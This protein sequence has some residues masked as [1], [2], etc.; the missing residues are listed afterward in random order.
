MDE[1]GCDTKS[2]DFGQI[3]IDRPF[4]EDKQLRE[5]FCYQKPKGPNVAKEWSRNFRFKKLLVQT[6]P[7]LDWLVKYSWKHDFVKDIIS[8]ITVAIMHIPQGMAYAMLGNVPA[9]VGIYMAFFPVM[10]YFIFG[11]SKHNSMGTFSVACLMTGK[12]VLEY[13]DPS[14]FSTKGNIDGSTLIEPTGY[15]PIQVA[16]AVTFI[17]ALFQLAMYFLRLG[18]I[19]ALLSET[20]VSGFT[21]GAAI[22]VLVS[23]IKDLFGLQIPK[24]K[25]N[26]S[27]VYTIIAI[28]G[29]LSKTN[30]AALIIS[31]ITI[32][33]SVLNN[34]FFKPIVA[35][36]SPLPFPME[37]IAVVVGTLMSK[38]CN[39]EA[40]Y[41]I[42]VVGDIPVGLPE[43]TLPEFSLLSNLIVDGITISI[44]TYTINLS[45]ALIFAQKLNYEVDA[46]QELLA[47]GLSNIFGS[48]FSCMPVCASLSRS[49]IQ[50]VVGGVSQIASII[51]CIILLTVLLWI[52]PFFQALPKAV[53]ASV[54]VVALKGMLMQVLDFW[55]FWKLSKIDALVWLGTFLSVVFIGIDIGLLCGVGLSLASIFFLSFKPHTCLLGH[56]AN[57][58]FY[59]DIKRYKAARE[60]DG[61]KIFHYAGGINFATKSIFKSDLIRL[62]GINPQKEVVNR[63]KLAKYMG[64]VDECKI[65]SENLTNKLEKVQNKVNTKLRCLI[66]DF[67]SVSHID[68]SG[69]SMLKSI[70]DSFMKLGIPVYIAHCKEPV[71]EMLT[72]VYPD[73][74]AKIGFRSF[75]T[76]HDAVHYATVLFSNSMNSSISTINIQF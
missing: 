23:Q 16:T 70:T 69:V 51:S 71:Y 34:D 47:M 24:F 49:L 29:E 62:I 2:E 7:V 63:A 25:G 43:P 14:Y 72:K 68:P 33:I 42:R 73:Y 4:Y 54:I 41:Q 26:F 13:S 12:A 66:L 67:S 46:N 55:K 28:F 1:D 59:L 65:N 5:D 22:H 48:F 20:L 38:Y 17:V 15:S 60:L 30:A 40:S 76:V 3:R 52:G 74:T 31:F 35:R 45:M 36:V 19:S 37:L 64:K 58:D 61:I 39:L 32:V 50:Q 10:I 18:A 75:P 56:V 9:V 8:G 27:N 44:V 6:I 53:L 11:T 21:T 57:T